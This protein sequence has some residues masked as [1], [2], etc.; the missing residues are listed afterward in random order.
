[1]FLLLEDKVDSVSRVGSLATFAFRSG[2]DGKLEQA[3]H[4][5]VRIVLNDTTGATD[6]L[7]LSR[8]E[9]KDSKAENTDGLEGIAV[10]E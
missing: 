8:T 3:T 7:Q 4:H 5:E 2:C 9:P 1:M 10:N 6:G